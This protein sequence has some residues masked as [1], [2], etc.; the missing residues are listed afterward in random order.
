MTSG[1]SRTTIDGP[2]GTLELA[3]NLPAAAP[4][5]IALI[6]HPHPLQGGTLDNK[7]AQ[8][9]AKAFVSLEYA[10]GALQLSRRRK[11]R[12]RVRQGYRRDR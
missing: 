11:K 2:A 3:F 8:T 10:R 7:V 5:G 12:G 9:L 6:A 1:E 4:R